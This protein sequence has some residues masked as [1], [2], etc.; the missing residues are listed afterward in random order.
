MIQPKVR[1]TTQR[2]GWTWKLPLDD[3]V[4]GL[5]SIV[6]ASDV[7]GHRELLIDGERGYLFKADDAEA[8]AAKL[9]D[10]IARQADWPAMRAA[11]R[12]YVEAERSWDRGVARYAPIYDKLVAARPKGSA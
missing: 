12:R 1:S 8:L 9:V 10:V 3:L 6:V 4:F 5:G 11:G 2:L 7:G